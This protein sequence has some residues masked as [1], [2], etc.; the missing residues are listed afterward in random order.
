MQ[1]EILNLL[2][3]LRDEHRLTYLMV[4]HNLAVVGHL[5]QSVA[6]MQHGRIVERLSVEELLEQRAGQAYTRQL[7]Q[8]S[9]GFVREEDVPLL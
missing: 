5:C 8:S 7:L 3:D 6:V 4:W 2:T 1:A 9:L